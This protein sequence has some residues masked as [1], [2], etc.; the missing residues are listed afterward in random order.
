MIIKPEII[1]FTCGDSRDISTWSNVPYLFSKTLEKKGYK[2]H[3][4][5]ISPNKL[6]NRIFNTSCFFVF[7]RMFKCK[8][9]PEFHRTWLHRF[10]TYCKI[11]K[12]TKQHPNIDFNLFLSFA[13]YNKYS[14]KPSI[15]WCDWTDRIVIERLGRKPAFYEEISLRHEDYVMRKADLVYTMFPVCKEHME[16]LY[17]RNIVYL[18][19]NVVNT[20]FEDEFNLESTI[21]NRYK[22]NTILFIGGLKYI[23]AAK[24]LIKSVK[25]LNKYSAS[26]KLH[27]IGITNEQIKNND[28]NI[29]CH[30]Y[31]RKNIKAQRDKYYHL[32]HN[33]KVFVNPARQWGGY[34]SSIE[35]LFYGCP[36]VVAPYNDFVK[37]FGKEICFGHYLDDNNLTNCI[38][39]ILD[40]SKDDYYN[41]C[42]CA[43]NS[44]ASY[45][46][47][48]YIDEFIESLKKEHVINE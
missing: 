20:V 3:R 45:T 30:G 29:I 36:I 47:D 46:W 25:Q 11:K 31:L 15:L 24:E 18:N 44:V 5:D 10:I 19:R 34:S 1:L 17:E 43:Y 9:C 33:C 42:K 41:M 6:L 16:E 13:F 14:N 7:K 12:A 40:S 8:A 27:I 38:K 21:K 48:N 37:E 22:S 2:L 4:V 28:E 39:K 35:A 23:T 26:F 32:L